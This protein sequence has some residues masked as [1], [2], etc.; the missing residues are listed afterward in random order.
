V[1]R[2]TELA[3]EKGLTPSA[4][5]RIVLMD[6]WATNSME[7]VDRELYKL[8]KRAEQRPPDGP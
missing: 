6:H 8:A 1:E 2:L 4:Y 7:E 5:I 3:Q